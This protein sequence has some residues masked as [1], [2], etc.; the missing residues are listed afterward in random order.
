L[1]FIDKNLLKTAKCTAYNMWFAARLT[2]QLIPIYRDV[3][4]RQQ[5]F[6]HQPP[7]GDLYKTQTR[8]ILSSIFESGLCSWAGRFSNTSPA[9][10]RGRWW[11]LYRQPYAVRQ[12]A[13]S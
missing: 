6:N 1:H 11:Q 5:I 2:G 8:I 7:Q 13:I 12:V 3:C 9:A 10:S 4:N